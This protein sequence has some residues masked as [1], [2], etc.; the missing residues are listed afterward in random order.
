M[1]AAKPFLALALTAAALPA[2]AAQWSSPESRARCEVLSAA[3]YGQ[4]GTRIQPAGPHLS[5]DTPD[6]AQD[7]ALVP[8]TLRVAPD[9]QATALDLIIDNN[10]SPVAAK[11]LFGPAGDPRQMKLRVRIDAFTNMHAVVRAAD[12]RLLRSAA[13]V[14]GA[15]GCSA[16]MGTSVSD[17]SAHMGEMRLRF[18]TEAALGDAPR[19][20][21]MIRHPNFNGMQSDSA[22]HVLTPSRYIQSI[23][24]SEGD[25]SVFKLTTD[26]SL[27]A[28][29]VLEFLYKREEGKS[30]TVTVKDSSGASW[31]QQFDPP[32]KG[33]Q[34]ER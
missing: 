33:Q 21:L 34:A 25:A 18:G 20:T 16:P 4:D 7:T 28:N 3:I 15:G 19:A 27:A 24:V 6:V 1:S 12:G 31:T 8:V 11:V 30:F 10:P 26:I 13:F 29:P 22:T 5:I 9:V 14:Q 2:A 17:V 32:P 23:A